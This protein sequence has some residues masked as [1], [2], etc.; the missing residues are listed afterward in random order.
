MSDSVLEAPVPVEQDLRWGA[1][2]SVQQRLAARARAFDF[3]QAV[4]LLSMIAD[5]E[6][7][8]ASDDVLVRFRSKMGFEFPG[9][10]IDCI[11]FSDDFSSLPEMTVN[12]MG[13]GGAHGPI[14]AAY[15]PQLL[16]ERDSAL[17]DFLDIFNHRLIGL[18]YRIHALHHPELTRSAPSQG[19][20]ANLL[21]AVFGLDRD[22]ESSV[23][24]RLQIPDRALLDY[25][26]LLA[27]GAHSANGLERLI[28]DYFQIPAEVSQFTGA[29]LPLTSD[30]WTRLGVDNQIIGESAILGRR[31]WDEHA[32][33]T[34]QLGPLDL[35]TFKS[36]LPKGYAYKQFRDLVRFYLRDEFEVTLKLILRSDQTPPAST[37]FSAK[38]ESQ[39]QPAILGR[40]AWL[41]PANAVT[42]NG[43]GSSKPDP[44]SDIGP[45]VTDG[46]L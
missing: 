3:Y 32:G 18:A 13:L 25:S 12:F 42:S 9:S 36:F 8:A 11:E 2:A 17:R 1:G 29:W 21:F 20:A 23:R 44:D 15:T 43:H 30:Q 45:A 28:Q 19:L 14:P 7:D 16:V 5:E 37:A 34:I 31:V 41:R 24:N 33:V 10:D 27:H 6:D 38:E 35:A 4:R 40:L 46:E 39:A 26:G 22:P